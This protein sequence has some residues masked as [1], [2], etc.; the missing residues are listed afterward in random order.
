M[1]RD[2][3]WQGETPLLCVARREETPDTASFE[4][5]APDGKI[6]DFRPG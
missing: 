3:F 4:L 2:T 1:T 6:F 5:V